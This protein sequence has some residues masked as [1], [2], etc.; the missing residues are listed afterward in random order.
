VQT[1]WKVI[2]TVLKEHAHSV[3]KSLRPPASESQ[4]VHL[5]EMVGELPRDFLN[6]LGIHD[7]MS[8][9]GVIH[10]VNYMTLVPI[11]T[12]ISDWKLLWK[13]QCECDCKGDQITRTRKIKND[14]HWRRGWVPIMDFEGDKFVLDLDPGPTGKRGQLIS[15]YNSGS[16]PMRVLADSFTAWLDN[17]AEVLKQRRFNLDEWGGIH[18]R[19]Q[20]A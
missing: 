14:A 15:W 7:G 19:K 16:R 2:E 12:I 5:A 13:L 3:Y 10:F 20:L 9:A 6:S 17:V 8:K 4:I 18:L 1:S 11:A